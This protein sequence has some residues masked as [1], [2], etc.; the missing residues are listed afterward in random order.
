MTTDPAG[1]VTLFGHWICPYSLRV[2][3]ALA[4]RGIAHEVVEVPPTA[5]RPH[6]FVVPAEFVDHSPKG[7]IPLVRIGSRYRADSLP[8]LEWLEECVAVRPLLPTEP[9]ERLL[10]RRRMAWIDANV[11]A[12]MVGVYCGTRRERI[13]ESA[14]ALAGALAAMG[15]WVG[16]RAWM[17]GEAPTLAEAT[18]VPVYVRLDALRRLGFAHPL[19]RRVAAHLERCTGL[20]GWDAVAWSEAQTDELVE[21]VER[22]R[23]AAG[24]TGGA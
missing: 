1:G 6:G 12:P 7:E 24:P 5:A 9:G 22:F 11:F 3:F 2:S 14:A 20:A 8:I 10:V 4:E 16:D 21:R 15:E 23:A 19:D 17:G 13:A 18:V